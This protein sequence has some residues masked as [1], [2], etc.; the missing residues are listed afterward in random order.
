MILLNLIVTLKDFDKNCVFLKPISCPLNPLLPP[1][2]LCLIILEKNP[3]RYHTYGAL[4][5]F[6]VT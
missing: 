4:K 3:A 1:T 2:P 6:K 5:K